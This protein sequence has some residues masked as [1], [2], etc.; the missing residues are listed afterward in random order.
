[1]AKVD[2]SPDG[3]YVLSGSLDSFILWDILQGR[4]IQTFD[5]PRAWVNDTTAVAFSP[6]GKYFASGSK[7]IKL[8]DL[9]TKQ[10]K[11]TFD[12][13][14]RTASVA[15]SPDGKNLL[16]GGPSAG[17][18]VPSNMQIYDVATGKEVRDF[19][20]AGVLWSVAYSPDGKY[21]L[22]GGSYIYG[23]RIDLWDASRGR[24][25]RTEEEIISDALVLA[26]SFSADG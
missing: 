12:D 8:W 10:E 2:I 15:F 3:R 21:A 22:S 9:S 23:G 14:I 19:D 20:P 7:G 1:M 24:L 25:I 16:S 13:N 11:S 4:K 5:H 18:R 6:D 17:S 26:V